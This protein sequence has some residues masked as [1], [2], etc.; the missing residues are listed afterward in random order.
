MSRGIDRVA[1]QRLAARLA[2]REVRRHP[3]R[4][5]LVVALMLLPTMATIGTFS[6]IATVNDVNRRS[7]EAERQGSI[8]DEPVGPQTADLT[9][10]AVQTG[11]RRLT[12]DPGVTRVEAYASA[13]DWLVTNRPRVDGF[14]PVLVAVDLLAA[15]PA[16]PTV[17]SDR[18][19]VD[20]G[21]FPRA[22]GEAFLTAPAATA[23]GWAVGDTV[24][25][26]RGRQRL[27]VVGI[28]RLRVDHRRPRVVLAP[29][30][31]LTRSAAGFDERVAFEGSGPM[32]FARVWADA[33]PAGSAGWRRDQPVT[34]L[35]PAGALVALGLAVVAGLTAV[36]A[37]VAFAVSSRRQLRAVG[38][39]ATAGG[40]PALVRAALLWQGV[41]PGLLAAG[42]AT[43]LSV[44]AIGLDHRWGLVDRVSPVVGAR[45]VV[46]GWGIAVAVAVSV[47]SGLLAAWF[48]ARSVSRSPILTALAARR[49]V[50]ALDARVPFAGA[51]SFVLGLVVLAGWLR[52]ADRSGEVFWVLLFP[53]VAVALLVLGAVGLAPLLVVAAAR[54]GGRCRGLPRLALRGLIRHRGQSSASVVAVAACLAVVVGLLAMDQLFLAQAPGSSER[55]GASTPATVDDGDR[56]VPMVA[57]D[58]AV[59]HLNGSTD[60][61]DV[62]ATATR[63]RAALRTPAVAVALRSYRLADGRWATVAEVPVADADRA[64]APAV[65]AAL[66]AGRAIAPDRASGRILLGEQVRSFP[67][68]RSDELWFLGS[69]RAVDVVVPAG[70][71]APA[72]EFPHTTSLTFLRDALLTRTEADALGRINVRPD[73]PDGGSEPTLAQVRGEADAPG[74]PLDEAATYVSYLAPWAPDPDRFPLIAAGAAAL[75]ALAVVTVTLVLRAVDQ[76][77][78]R[79]AALAAGAPPAGLRRLVVID[80]AV[81]TGLGALLALP[82]GWLPVVVVARHRADPVPYPGWTTLGALVLPVV[83]VAVTWT[84]LPWLW[85]VARDRGR[86]RDLL[87]PRS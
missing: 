6:T 9:D 12:G 21:R 28:G 33:A 72:D 81:L 32:V 20:T 76:E 26:A 70:S 77:D 55:R 53:M 41:L 73:Q 35:G 24:E 51:T 18:F 49:P 14:G 69:G 29:G 85:S 47:A 52:L 39:L 56:R 1:R 60:P 80:G 50:G 68:T 66:R 15:E 75:L 74:S 62:T 64:F 87:L 40:D 10:P 46:S 57:D 34:L 22:R 16:H 67:V 79:R 30:T 59:V 2:R 8:G 4:L 71:L 23:G 42:L 84:V 58:A 83:L 27:T 5:A 48:P 31:S 7:H 37:S 78:D 19:V 63:V 11:I 17:V 3:W 38:L 44:V 13:D 54:A 82:V 86:G 36:I 65:V 43:V 45:L 25:V 61:A